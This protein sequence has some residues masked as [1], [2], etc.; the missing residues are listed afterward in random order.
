MLRGMKRGMSGCLGRWLRGEFFGGEF[1]CVS[2]AGL[3][4]WTALQHPEI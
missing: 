1:D 3:L 4:S 2:V